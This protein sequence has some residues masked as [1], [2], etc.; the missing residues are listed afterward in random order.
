MKKLF[1]PML[2]KLRKFDACPNYCI[3]YRSLQYEKLES[4]PHCS[5][6]LYKRNSGCRVYGND[7]GAMGGSKKKKKKKVP[8][9]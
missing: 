4:Y 1:Q 6:S 2:M 3:L 9:D 7:E 8:K 5:V